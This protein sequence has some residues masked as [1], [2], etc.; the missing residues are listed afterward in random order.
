MSAETGS[1][2]AHPA[3]GCVA[4]KGSKYCSEYC[5]EGASLTE[6]ACQCGHTSCENVIDPSR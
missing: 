4:N 1:K 2:C 5:E 6:I 3:C